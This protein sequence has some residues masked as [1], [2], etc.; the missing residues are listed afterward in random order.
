MTL[1]CKLKLDILVEQSCQRSGDFSE[2][3]DKSPLETSMTKEISHG[4]DVIRWLKACHNLNLS[5][6]NLYAMC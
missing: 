5:S 4:F 3:L 1:Y 2:I 6:V